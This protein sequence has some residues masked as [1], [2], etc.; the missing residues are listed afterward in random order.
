MLEKGV[1]ENGCP[2]QGDGDG[3]P[4]YRESC[5]GIKRGVKAGSQGAG[6]AERYY[7]RSLFNAFE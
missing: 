1:V 7:A 3:L 4:D 2:K 5:P 6:W